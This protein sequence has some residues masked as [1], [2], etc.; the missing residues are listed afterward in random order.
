M[1]SAQVPYSLLKDS[2]ATRRDKCPHWLKYSKQWFQY[3]QKLKEFDKKVSVLVR[4]YQDM[5]IPLPHRINKHLHFH[6]KFQC[7]ESGPTTLQFTNILLPLFHMGITHEEYY[8]VPPK[9]WLWLYRGHALHHLS[10][11]C[12]AALSGETMI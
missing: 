11:W 8:Y 4:S 9:F 12:K 6:I 5:I 1:Q 10:S 7:I 3:F 2:G